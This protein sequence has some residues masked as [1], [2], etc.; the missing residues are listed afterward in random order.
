MKKVKKFSTKNICILGIGIALYVVLSLCLQVPIFENYYLCLGYLVM[1]AYLY[2]Y[3]TLY[4]T[5]IG[6]IGC[7]LYCVL[8]NGLRGMPG[9]VFGNIVIGIIIGI[10]IPKLKNIKNV[11]LKYIVYL[12][13]VTLA[14]A[15]GILGIKSIT[16][17][18]LYSQPFIV[19]IAKNFNAFVADVVMLIL[20]IPIS[21]NIDKILKK[22]NLL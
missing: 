13:I 6:A 5:I 19:R 8:I 22:Q 14:T 11:Y 18:I 15:L 16:E 1:M 9:W 21:V 7:I 20:S 4:G 10:T 3:G 12:I 17:C 2:S